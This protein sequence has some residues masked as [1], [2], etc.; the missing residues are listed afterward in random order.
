MGEK[1][2][3][4]MNEKVDNV[5]VEE[6]P[7]AVVTHQ[8]AQQANVV[9]VQPMQPVRPLPRQWS[10]GYFGLC[11]LACCVPCVGIY[12]AVTNGPKEIFHQK[13]FVFNWFK[14][15]TLKSMKT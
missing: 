8:P 15:R 2:E 11:C 7:T 10:R 12:Y 9:Y 5:Q 3:P 4:E 6:I 13:E 1:V 14:C